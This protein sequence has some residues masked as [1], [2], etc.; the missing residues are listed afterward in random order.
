MDI[1]ILGPAVLGVALGYILMAMFMD[2]DYDGYFGFSERFE[3]SWKGVLMF[4]AVALSAGLIAQYPESVRP[5]SGYALGVG[6]G[7]FA[8]ELIRFVGVRFFD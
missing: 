7:V 2:P 5:F 8:R 6:L 1:T 3:P 4:V